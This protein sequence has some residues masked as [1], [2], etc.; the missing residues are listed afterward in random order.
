M[1]VYISIYAYM[2]LFSLCISLNIFMF[3]ATHELRGSF[4]EAYL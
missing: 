3:I 4:Y 2:F 1:H